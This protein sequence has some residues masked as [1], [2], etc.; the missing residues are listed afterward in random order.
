MLENPLVTAK[1]DE[2]T[3]DFDLKN[4]IKIDKKYIHKVND[5]NNFVSRIEQIA[6]GDEDVFLSQVYIDTSHPY[7]FEH[8]YDHIPGMMMIEAGRQIGT[9][10]AHLFYHVSFD[11]VFILNEM[12]IRFFKYVEVVKPLFIKSMVRNKLM[13]RDKL[14]QMEHDGHFIQDGREVGYMSGT[15]QMYDKRIIDRFRKS[16]RNISL[17]IS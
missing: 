16:A 9:A 15:W 7:Y 17:D 2:W 6:S 12:T 11:T 4:Q 3:R 14:I 1:L 13:K 10:V 8:D 5:Q